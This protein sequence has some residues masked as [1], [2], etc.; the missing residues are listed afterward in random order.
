V[1]RGEGWGATVRIN[2][3]YLPP[4][5]DIEHSVLRKVRREGWER[6]GVTEPERIEGTEVGEQKEYGN[7]EKRNERTNERTNKRRN[8]GRTKEQ[9]NNEGRRKR[10]KRWNEGRKVGRIFV[11][12]R[13]Y[14]TENQ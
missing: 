2:H 3:N 11:S 10:L 14:W 1:G 8:D 9:R 12:W 13:A 6:R 4:V 7:Q 5:W